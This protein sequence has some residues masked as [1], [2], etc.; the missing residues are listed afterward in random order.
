MTGFVPFGEFALPAAAGAVLVAVACENG[1]SV[2]FT[3]YSAAALLALIVSPV[4]E[5]A[6]LFAAFFGYYPIICPM[7]S[8][9]KSKAVRV[10][11]K[12][13]IFNFSVVGGYFLLIKIFGFQL[14]AAA[15]HPLAKFALL[16]LLVMGNV[17]FL[18]YDFLIK[19]L[20]PIYLTKFRTK[21]LGKK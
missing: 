7:L 17:F 2:A 16:G 6:V 1:V 15:N 20:Y 9:I 4:K 12:F 8:K 11:A 10:A 19:L 3:V 18:L 14:G 5:S 13:G 21:Y